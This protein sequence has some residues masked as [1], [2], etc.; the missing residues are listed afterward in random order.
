MIAHGDIRFVIEDWPH[1]FCVALQF[2][3][4]GVTPKD[5]WRRALAGTLLD[6]VPPERPKTGVLSGERCGWPMNKKTNGKLGVKL[7][8]LVG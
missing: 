3:G 6:P 4:G 2:G 1:G 8:A 5:W 7:V